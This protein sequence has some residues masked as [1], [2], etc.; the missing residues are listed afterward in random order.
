[1]ATARQSYG[2]SIELAFNYNDTRER[3]NPRKIVY[4]M[5]E[6]DY[7][8]NVTPIIYISLSVDLDLYGKIIKYKNEA[9]FYLSINK[10]NLNSRNSLNKNHIE[11]NFAYI[12]SNTSENYQKE[13]ETP[14][15]IS[16]ESSY[17]NILIGLISINLNN[18]LR[19]CFNSVYKEVDTETLLGI[20]LD[21][22][23][24][25]VESPKYNTEYNQLL[26]P[27]LTS[28]YKFIDYIFNLDPFYDS[29]FRFFMDFDKVYLSSKDN[30]KLIDSSSNNIKDVIISIESL[31]DDAAY[32]DGITIKNNAYYIYEN[33][34]NVNTSINESTEKVANKIIT[35]DD[36]KGVSEYKLNINNRL[37]SDDIPIFLR[38]NNSLYEKN[39][40]ESSAINIEIIKQH[41]DGSL[42]TPDM[43]IHIKQFGEY[44]KYN[45][46]YNILKKK[47]FYKAAGGGDFIVSCVG[48]FQLINSD[49]ANTSNS[50][51]STD[52]TSFISSSSDI[53]NTSR[54][55]NTSDK[56]KDL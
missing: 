37:D 44:S 13:L 4:V 35:V 51:K 49:Q 7:E 56:I 22:T 1:M 20:A 41:I 5:I 48:I 32:V 2:A 23:D 18:R 39:R 52:Y 33:P 40:L 3:I 29:K 11:G 38:S 36:I 27:P 25:I 45:G 34:T 26:I 6:S 21:G 15:S 50:T 17:K 16:A 24:Y 30:T 55:V 54:L 31:K 8:N 42:F 46:K 53:E 19:K 10:S 12:P 47:E 9:T 43:N 14:E 28:R